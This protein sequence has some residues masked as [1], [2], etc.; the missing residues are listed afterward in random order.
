MSRL[1]FVWGVLR[2]SKGV[3]TV[4]NDDEVEA[5]VAQGARTFSTHTIP[6]GRADRL[7][8]SRLSV[9]NATPIAGVEPA[10]HVEL[11]PR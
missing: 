3:F 6:L 2:V 4:L 10:F 9:A 8:I 1:V 11:L 5:L 7:E